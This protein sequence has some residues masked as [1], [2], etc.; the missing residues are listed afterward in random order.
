MSISLQVW[1]SLYCFCG[2]SKHIG[3]WEDLFYWVTSINWSSFKSMS[4]ALITKCSIHEL[5]INRSSFTCWSPIYYIT[6][7]HG[8]AVKKKLQNAV[9][10][11]FLTQYKRYHKS[12]T[13]RWEDIVIH[14]FCIGHCV[15]RA[16]LIELKGQV[17]WDLSLSGRYL[18]QSATQPQNYDQSESK[19]THVV[20]LYE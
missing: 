8:A 14:I 11:Q 9:D 17:I 20:S 15:I 1:V 4:F 12:K 13:W 7:F 3:N 10:S 5:C 18:P 6:N 19:K 16:K 2:Q